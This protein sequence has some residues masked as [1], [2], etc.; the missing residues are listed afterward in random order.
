[1]RKTVVT[2]VER[3]LGLEAAAR[4]AGH[5]GTE[6]TRPHYVE[7]NKIVPDHTEALSE[8]SRRIGAVGD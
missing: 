2:A 3:H 4:Q 7:R 1:M 5:A 6:V 8:F